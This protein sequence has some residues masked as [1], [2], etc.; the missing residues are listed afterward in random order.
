M[1]MPTPRTITVTDEARAID[2]IVLAFAADPVTRWCW[3]DSHQYLASM[4]SFIRAFAGGAFAHR[5]AHSTDDYAGAALWLPPAVHPDEAIVTD[6]WKRT[7][8]GPILGDL[9][10]VFEQMAKFHPPE[11]HWYLPLI[12]VDPTHQ[13]KGVGGA[14]L[15][16]ALQQCDRD[17]RPAYLESTNPRN[18]P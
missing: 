5:S 10:A 16:H 13:G 3:P 17:H 9:A 18:V 1:R 15:A 14:L 4:P 7:V 12:G 8:S 11:P 6:L 2:T